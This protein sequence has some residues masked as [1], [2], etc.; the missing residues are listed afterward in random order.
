MRELQDHE[1]DI[2]RHTRQA[3]DDMTHEYDEEIAK[4]EHV[5]QASLKK[6]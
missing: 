2:K 4:A 1:A 6:F 5:Y 3:F